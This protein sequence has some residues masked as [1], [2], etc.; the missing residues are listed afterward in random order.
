MS[1][2]THFFL[3]ILLQAVTFQKTSNKSSWWRNLKATMT[4]TAYLG[5]GPGSFANFS[6]LQQK[7]MVLWCNEIKMAHKPSKAVQSFVQFEVP[8]ACHQ[9]TLSQLVPGHGLLPHRCYSNTMATY[10]W[11]TCCAPYG[12][13][14]PYSSLR[15]LSNFLLVSY[16]LTS[17]H[18]LVYHLPVSANLFLPLIGIN[19]WFLNFASRFESIQNKD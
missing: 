18:I 10:S 19:Q 1:T 4:H 11:L 15:E 12:A 3:L 8:V 13:L 5:P 16:P 6:C 17:I 2:W 7:V 9:I 14:A